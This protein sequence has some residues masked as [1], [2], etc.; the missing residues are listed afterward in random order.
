M[1]GYC[2]NPLAVLL[3][4]V[5]LKLVGDVHFSMELLVAIG[6][7]SDGFPSSKT[8]MRTSP[9]KAL[10][11]GNLQRHIIELRALFDV[12]LESSV[13][14][15][16]GGR[17]N[18]TWYSCPCLVKSRTGDKVGACRLLLVKETLH[19][20]I[21]C[22]LGGISGETGPH[23]CFA[24]MKTSN[25]RTYHREQLSATSHFDPS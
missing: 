9:L 22:L 4:S 18:P 12:F 10:R 19:M 7:A 25:S 14:C 24:R 15:L 8:Q 5:I 16:G 23:L 2:L 11:E 13:V 1:E 17:S 21:D 6:L 20:G 3:I